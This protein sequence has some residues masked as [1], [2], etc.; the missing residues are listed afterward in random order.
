MIPS[1]HGN[2]EEGVRNTTSVM[3]KVWG[4]SIQSYIPSWWAWWAWPSF[5]CSQGRPKCVGSGERLSRT[6]LGLQGH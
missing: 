2:S 3:W 4:C 1:C 5:G 6:S